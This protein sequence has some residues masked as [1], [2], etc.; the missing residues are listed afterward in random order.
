MRVALDP[1]QQKQ[2]SCWKIF[3]QVGFELKATAC[4]IGL[5]DKE[6]A[7]EQMFREH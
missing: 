3:P 5:K 1:T 4:V 7:K 2:N 6:P